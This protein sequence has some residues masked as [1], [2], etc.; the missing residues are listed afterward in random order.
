MLVVCYSPS[1]Q[2]PCLS[3]VFNTAHPVQ[4]PCQHADTKCIYCSYLGSLFLFV[5]LA[6]TLFALT[7]STLP[8]YISVSVWDKRFEK[9]VR[10]S[11]AQHRLH[12]QLPLHP[13]RGRTHQR[14]PEDDIIYEGPKDAPQQVKCTRVSRR[15][16]QA[17]DSVQSPTQDV[18][19]RWEA[20]DSNISGSSALIPLSSF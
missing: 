13:S 7:V 20:Q 9:Q 17:P 4:N 11:F 5:I 16:V 3:A 18:K 19:I 8:S 1:F 2:D 6:H 12:V 10:T 15:H 14:S